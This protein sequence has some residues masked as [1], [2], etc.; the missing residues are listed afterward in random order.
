MVS[1]F[2]GLPCVGKHEEKKGVG[3]K[4]VQRRIVGYRKIRLSVITVGE[5]TRWE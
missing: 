5:I 3:R 4:G 1:L 2:L